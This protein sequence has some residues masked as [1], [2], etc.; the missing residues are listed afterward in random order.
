[1]AETK[2]ICE[3]SGD[4]IPFP[5]PVLIFVIRFGSPPSTGTTH[6]CEL[7][8]RF[9]S[10]NTFLPSGDHLGLPS[11]FPFG[12]VRALGGVSP[13]VL[14]TQRLVVDLFSA[15]FIVV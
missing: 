6:S 11:F 2:A 9:D 7:P 8:D 1:M 4:Q 14:A 10:N 13:S 3:P 5:A 15:R 12:S